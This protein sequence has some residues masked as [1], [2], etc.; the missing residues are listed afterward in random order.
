MVLVLFE[1]S[2][3]IEQLSMTRARRSIRDLMSVAPEKALVA[4]GSGK[5]VEMKVES[6][7][8]VHRCALRR[9][10]AFRLTARLSK[11]YNARPVHGDG[12]IHAGRKKDR[13]Q[14][15]GPGR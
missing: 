6:V 2:E 4:Q 1:I 7:G 15:C 12:R 3:A 5:Y 9:A 11:H 14:R 8:L 13:G 10:T